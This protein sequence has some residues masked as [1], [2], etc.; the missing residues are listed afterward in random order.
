MSHVPKTSHINNLQPF[1]QLFV[2]LTY[3]VLIAVTVQKPKQT[4]IK[5]KPEQTKTEPRSGPLLLSMLIFR[6]H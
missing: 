3:V 1:G 2:V 5:N 6:L 4:N